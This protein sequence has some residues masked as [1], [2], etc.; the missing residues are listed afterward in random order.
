MQKLTQVPNLNN[1]ATINQSCKAILWDMDGTLMATEPVH[2][3]AVKEFV[4]L[5]K[6]QGPEELN[7]LINI[8]T[9]QTDSIVYQTLNTRKLLRNITLTDFLVQKNEKTLELLKNK[10]ELSAYSDDITQFIVESSKMGI[11]HVVVTSS[12]KALAH[13]FLTHFNIIQY[14]EF[15]ITR[16]DT[17]EN[18]PSPMPYHLALQK[19]NLSKEDIIIFEDSQIGLTAAAATTDHYCHANWY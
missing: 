7:H 8:C 3:A 4:D 1:L 17:S 9:G 11:K 6:I 15:I 18:K 19:L 10:P 5:E 2:I 13:H 14:F 12:E 16:E